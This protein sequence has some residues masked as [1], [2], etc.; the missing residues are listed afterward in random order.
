MERKHVL[1]KLPPDVYNE[2]KAA[3]VLEGK[4][5]TETIE[6]FMKDYVRR[7]NASRVKDSRVG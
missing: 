2:F 4:T 6:K 5:I 1:L 3:V 7:K